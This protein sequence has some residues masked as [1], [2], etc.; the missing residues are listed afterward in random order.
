[1]KWVSRAVTS[2]S[3]KNHPNKHSFKTILGE[4]PKNYPTQM[5]QQKNEFFQNYEYL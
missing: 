5:P 1:M 3:P 4:L 2:Q